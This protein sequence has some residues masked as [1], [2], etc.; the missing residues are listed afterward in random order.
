VTTDRQAEK[1]EG[2]NA[3]LINIAIA[4]YHAKQAELD[5]QKVVKAGG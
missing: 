5:V 2:I 3:G 4:K 1:G